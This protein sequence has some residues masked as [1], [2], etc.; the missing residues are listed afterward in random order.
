MVPYLRFT[1]IL[2]QVCWRKCTKKH[3]KKNLFYKGFLLREK[4]NSPLFIKENL[5]NKNILLILFVLIK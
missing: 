5:L 1:S 3:W 2:V 4:K